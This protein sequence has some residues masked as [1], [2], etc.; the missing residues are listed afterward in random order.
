MPGN[1]GTPSPPQEEAGATGSG[2]IPYPVN[3]DAQVFV[4]P[5]P[6]ED[7][8][9]V[10]KIPGS[11]TAPPPLMPTPPP[12]QPPQEKREEKKS[13]KTVIIAAAA[14][15]VVFL[16]LASCICAGLY[17]ARN[18][19]PDDAALLIG[20]WVEKTPQD[21]SHIADRFYFWETRT[22]VFQKRDNAT[23]NFN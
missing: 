2:G 9:P 18:S 13:H 3:D 22:G 12:S 14:A 11:D 10:E 23:F 17:S 4:Q 16:I 15:V 6:P 5:A 21:P 8:T 7:A 19:A 20:R 1:T